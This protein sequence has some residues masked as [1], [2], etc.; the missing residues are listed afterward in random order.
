[1]ANPRRLKP[2]LKINYKGE[3]VP[4]WFT[5]KGDRIIKVSGPG[6][7]YIIFALII[8]FVLMYLF[9]QIFIVIGGVLLLISIFAPMPLNWRFMLMISSVVF[10]L[11]GIW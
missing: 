7:G 11:I 1:M 3:V 4:R 6:F 5:N 10:L 2:N 9:G 8:F